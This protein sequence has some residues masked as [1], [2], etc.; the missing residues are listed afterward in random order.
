MVTLKNQRLVQASYMTGKT[1]K[2]AIISYKK[3][4]CYIAAIVAT[5]W[6][7][8]H[9]LCRQ[10]HMRRIGKMNS[11][12]PAAEYTDIE[13]PYGYTPRPYQLE[14]WNYFMG[15]GKRA[16][17]IWHR[18]AGKDLFGVNLA[19]TMGYMRPGLYWHVLPTYQQGRKIVWNG[20]IGDGR[21]FLDFMPKDL[22]VGTHD[23]DMRMEFRTAVP[24]QTSIWQVV[25]SD[26]VDRLVGT[27]PV[28]LIMSE[29]SLQNPEAWNLL[30]PILA[31]NGGW[32]L[33]QYTP[34]GRNH[35]Y[36]MME[37]AKKTPHWFFSLKTVEDTKAIP[38]SVIEEE[39]SSGM[40]EEMV[41]QEYYCSFEA[42]LVGSYYGQQLKKIKKQG[43]MMES[44]LNWEPRLDVGTAWDLGMDDTNV[45]IFY[46]E[47][48]Q[49]IRIIHAYA[50]S[51]E[52]LSHYARHLREQEYRYSKHY[53]P[54]DL[55]VRELST[56]KSRLETARQMGIK[57]D[58][59]KKLSVEDG[60]EAV[61]NILPRCW[62]NMRDEGVKTLV[63]ALEEYTKEWDPEKKVFRERPLHNWCSHWAD[64]FKTL[65]IG[66]RGNGQQKDVHPPS[67]VAEYNEF[68]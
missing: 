56:G 47:H 26:E 28:G 59:V 12:T 37:V 3:V 19:F 36:D 15:G 53:G 25:G 30:R 24:G 40:P 9:Y 14:A 5:V 51:G 64:A 55:K 22:V 35:G 57:F 45:I 23:Q 38:L 20:K 68:G 39:R 43:H 18:R 33:F 46:Q 13:L 16:A 65:A 2:D 67:A 62:F 54:H 6:L 21:R 10:Y 48:G 66:I 63:R 50:N 49:D 52:G 27:N 11:S 4:T 7:D 31:E 8:K 32:V 60:I 1:V 34:R 44:G 61:R 58:V 17:C 29:Y 42:S 41:Q